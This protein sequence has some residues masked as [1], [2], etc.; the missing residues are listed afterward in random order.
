MLNESIL[1]PCVCNDSRVAIYISLLLWNRLSFERWL[2]RFHVTLQLNP[3]SSRRTREASRSFRWTIHRIVW[4]A[5][6]NIWHVA[7]SAVMK[8]SDCEWLGIQGPHFYPDGT[9]KLVT[10]CE[11]CISVRTFCWKIMILEWNKWVTFNVAVSIIQ[12]LWPNDP[13]MLN[14]LS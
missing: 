4:A 10:R 11:T 2:Q 1:G 12:F 3:H 8:K 7:D 14:T 6:G 5:A 9:F 13:H